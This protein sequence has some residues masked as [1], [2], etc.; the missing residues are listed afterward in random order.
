MS[1]TAER[2]PLKLFVEASPKLVWFG[3]PITVTLTMRTPQEYAVEFPPVAAFGEIRATLGET[4]DPRPAA[5]G[6]LEW[7]Q[8]YTV[9]SF[10]AGTLE[11]PPLA[12]KYGKR[13]QTATSRPASNV[14]SKLPAAAA[15]VFENEIAAGTL[16]IEVRSA[17]TSQ[18]ST[19]SPRDVTGTIVP[20]WRLTPWEW[21]AVAG[22]A[23]LGAGLMFGVIRW[24]QIRRRR[25]PPPIAPEVWA[26]RALAELSGG[27][28]IESGRAKEFYYRLSEVVRKYV[29]LKFSV[30][31]PEM[32]TEEFLVALSRDRGALPFDAGRLRPF[33]NACDLVKYA[34]YGP[35]REDAEEALG[36]AR[37]FVDSTAAAA[38]MHPARSD[39]RTGEA[40][41]AGGK[42]A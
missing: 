18:D 21:A 38:A 37:S 40:M 19:M 29:E 8:T 34:A 41:Q 15:V 32:T 1:D 39:M 25:P 42:A 6:G 22:I 28:W 23:I 13:M 36:T 33:M 35:P 9:E 26:L 20:P 30:A 16:K 17:L 2:G 10:T 4:R 27:D 14:I 12:V 3:D 24:I 11:I 5:D 7:R 31:A